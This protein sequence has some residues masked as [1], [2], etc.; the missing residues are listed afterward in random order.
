MSYSKLFVYLIRNMLYGSYKL[1]LCECFEHIVCIMLHAYV[2]YVCAYLCT[3]LNNMLVST[4]SHAEFFCMY[5]VRTEITNTIGVEPG[6]L[7]L[8]K[9]I[10]IW[11]LTQLKWKLES[12]EGSNV[13]IESKIKHGIR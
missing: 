9:V 1:Y 13:L 8:H 12:Y 5:E 2:N 11:R 4:V 3:H 6:K 10:N 7:S